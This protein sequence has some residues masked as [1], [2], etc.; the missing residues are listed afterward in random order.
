MTSRESTTPATVT[1]R[2]RA[3]LADFDSRTRALDRSVET[4][5]ERALADAVRGLLS[6]PPAVEVRSRDAADL[7]ARD[8]IVRFFSEMPEV[9][10]AASSAA[11]AF[12]GNVDSGFLIGAAVKL[13][14]ISRESLLELVTQAILESATQVRVDTADERF[15]AGKAALVALDEDIAQWGAS[16][17]RNSTTQDAAA[18]LRAF[19]NGPGSTRSA[20]PLGVLD[21][22]SRALRYYDTPSQFAAD[23]K[24]HPFRASARLA[25]ALRALTS[26]LSSDEVS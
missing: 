16:Y 17:G 7:A 1:D 2:A 23:P 12:S 10:A 3:A 8:V 5:M 6:A 15:V 21:Q 24:G 4:P 18:A 9:H 19:L 25:A 11:E 13:G 26:V 22:A 20:V 14:S